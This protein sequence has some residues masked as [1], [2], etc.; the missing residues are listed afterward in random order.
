MTGGDAQKRE[1]GVRNAEREGIGGGRQELED[2]SWEIGAVQMRSSE[3]RGRNASVRWKRWRG[4]LR[5]WAVQRRIW[6]G[7][8]EI[9][10]GRGG[11]GAGRGGIGVNTARK[12]DRS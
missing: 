11:G 2:R 9:W 4:S 7:P 12:G 1:R 6:T 5:K 10:T 8:H 3:F